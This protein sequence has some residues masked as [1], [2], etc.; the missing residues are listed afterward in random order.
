V[1]VHISLLL[2]GESPRL[3]GP[4]EAHITRLAEVEGPLP[5]ILVDRRSMRV[6]DGNHRLKAAVLQGSATIDVV[7]FEGTEADAFLYAVQANV[8]HGLPLSL[9]DRRAA[10]LRITVS[11]PHMSDRLI[12]EAAGLGSTTVAAIRHSSAGMAPQPSARIGKDGKLRPLD[13]AEGRHRAAALMAEHP[14]NSL[15]EVA[16][17]AGVSP[18]T[19]SDVRR[20]LERGEEPVPTRPAADDGSPPRGPAAIQMARRAQQATQPDPVAAI[21]KLLRDPSLRYRESGRQL[22]LLLQYNAVGVR[23]WA[24]LIASA[25]PHCRPLVGQLAKQYAQMW[26]ELAQELDERARRSVRAVG[27]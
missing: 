25:P 20:R 18:A 12:A 17:S 16:R 4:D 23:K 24:D 2:P 11:H 27:K 14:Q 9:A 13:G 19:A 6:I 21:E 22:L 10:A 8:A 5:P 15:R 3:E 1:T 7:Y 26:A